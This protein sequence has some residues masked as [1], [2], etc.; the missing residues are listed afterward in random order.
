ML[1]KDYIPEKEIK[2]QSQSIPKSQ[3]KNLDKIME[4]HKC[5]ITIKDGTHG[6]GFF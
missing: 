5:K 2:G 6:T 1:G 3:L 4:I